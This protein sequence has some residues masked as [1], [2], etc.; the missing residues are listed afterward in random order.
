VPT[1]NLYDKENTMSC[2]IRSR[3]ISKLTKLISLACLSTGAIAHESDSHGH[4]HKA[5]S[6]K[7]T[8]HSAVTQDVQL[9]AAKKKISFNQAAN[10]IQFQEDFAAFAKKLSNRYPNRISRIWLEPAPALEANIEFVGDMPRITAPQ[11]VYLTGGG[12]FNRKQHLERAEKLSEIIRSAGYNN[13]LTY[14]SPADG[15]IQLEMSVENRSSAM[16]V[17]TLSEILSKF[18]DE[19]SKAAGMSLSINDINLDI[20]E[21]VGE[22]YTMEHSRGGNWLRDDGARECT[23]GWSVSGPNGDGIITAAHCTGL[24]QFEESTTTI[25]GMTFR[26][27]ERGDGDVEY[28]TTDHIEPAEFW[29][30]ST[31]LRDVESTKATIWMLPGNSVCVYGRSSNVRDCTHKIEATGVTVTF[32][33]GVTVRKLVRASGDS[34]IGGDSGGGWSWGTKAWG[35]HSGSND[36]DSYFTP[37]GRAETELNVTIKTK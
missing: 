14:F 28:H 36:V 7:Q 5:M 13:F 19:D 27:Q 20:Q 12:K 21:R 18:S 35:V 33:D 4:D 10:A 3:S 25:Y 22:I 32:T 31:A 29:A 17:N 34:S 26:S 8:A 30:S 6:A 1:L 11:N 37:V 23:S 2:L 24:N 15:K 9:L 16:S